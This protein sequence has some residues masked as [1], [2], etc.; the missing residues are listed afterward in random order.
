M[1]RRWPIA[2]RVFLTLGLV[3]WISGS[4]ASGLHYLLVQHVVCV[5]HGD[6]IELDSHGH[7]ATVLVSSGIEISSTQQHGHPDHGCDE[8][9]ADRIGVPTVAW[10]APHFRTAQHL[11]D[12]QRGVTA[13]RGP[14][15]AYAPKTGPP[16][17]S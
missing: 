12:V 5:D 7:E 6:V 15:L 14:P 8:D 1:L 17:L 2:T 4:F 3:A 13:P 9:L 11:L 10:V 16:T